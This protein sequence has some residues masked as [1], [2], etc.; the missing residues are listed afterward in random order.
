MPDIL[1]VAG[2]GQ[3]ALEAFSLESG[4]HGETSLIKRN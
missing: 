4:P 2:K 3:Q 1:G